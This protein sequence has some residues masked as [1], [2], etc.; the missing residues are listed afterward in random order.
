M[1]TIVAWWKALKL[2]WKVWLSFA[3]ICVILQIIWFGMLMHNTIENHEYNFCLWGLYYQ[4]KIEDFIQMQDS[5]NTKMYVCGG[6]TTLSTRAGI[7]ESVKL[8]LKGW[9]SN[10]IKE[11]F[12]RTAMYV[13]PVLLWL[14]GSFEVL[15]WYRRNGYFG[16]QKTNKSVNNIPM[17]VEESKEESIE[18]KPKIADPKQIIET[19]PVEEGP[20]SFLSEEQIEEIIKLR[21]RLNIKKKQDG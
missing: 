19:K 5:S 4:M 21:Q 17:K 7:Y 14:I 13:Y 11:H 15:W 12:F 2:R 3:I 8:F 18:E 1:K 9:I 10:K 6:D 20:K 16:S